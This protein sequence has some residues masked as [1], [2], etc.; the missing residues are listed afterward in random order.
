M[1][2]VCDPEFVNGSRYVQW[3][4]SAFNV[5]AYSNRD[6]IGF[7]C[8]TYKSEKEREYLCRAE[9]PVILCPISLYILYN[10]F[11]LPFFASSSLRDFRPGKYPFLVICSGPSNLHE[12]SK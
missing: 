5:C 9:T 7:I 10:L 3:I 2:C 12:L 1:K 4:G 8:G 11:L 6:I